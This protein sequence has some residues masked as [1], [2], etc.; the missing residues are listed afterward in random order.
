MLTNIIFNKIFYF[1][2]PSSNYKAEKAVLSDQLNF[3][4]HTG[5]REAALLLV[6]EKCGRY[7]LIREPLYLDRCVI[8]TE[9]DWDDYFEVNEITSKDTFIFKVSF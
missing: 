3:P 5:I 2:Q 7:T 9:S 4:K 8:Y 1:V 6:K